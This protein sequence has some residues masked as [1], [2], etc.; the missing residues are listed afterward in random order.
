MCENFLNYLLPSCKIKSLEI[1]D[2]LMRMIRT[3]GRDR[4]ENKNNDMVMIRGR[5]RGR[6]H[7]YPTLATPRSHL[8][9]LTE[10]SK[11]FQIIFLKIAGQGR[12][13]KNK[14]RD[15]NTLT[16]ESWKS[17]SMS[18]SISLRL[19][20]S[21]LEWIFDRSNGFPQTIQWFHFILKLFVIIFFASF[22]I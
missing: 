6:R 1:V 7:R 17:Y 11:D 13:S 22:V 2:S 21:S 14:R 3:S 16:F 12:H 9:W 10:I 4:N 8:N 19:K 18:E 20:S 5:E 15:H